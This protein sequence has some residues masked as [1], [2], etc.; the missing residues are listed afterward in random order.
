MCRLY[1]FKGFEIYRVK[2]SVVPYLPTIKYW[3]NYSYKTK[4]RETL[5]ESPWTRRRKIQFLKILWSTKNCRIAA[6]EWIAMSTNIIFQFFLCTFYFISFFH[7]T[8]FHIIQQTHNVV[9]LQRSL[10][11]SKFFTS[12]F[13]CIVTKETTKAGIFNHIQLTKI[14]YFYIN[15]FCY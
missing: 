7:L 1:S 14:Q 4:L 15:I 2:F 10:I 3:K 8:S 6:A 12:K 11:G 9:M 5:I 13:Y